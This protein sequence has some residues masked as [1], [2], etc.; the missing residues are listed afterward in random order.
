V[1][2]REDVAQFDLRSV[3]K[4]LHHKPAPADELA[5]VAEPH[6]PLAEAMGL[7][8]DERPLHPAFRGGTIG[9]P[10]VT[11]QV[12]DRLVGVETNVVVGIRR[13]EGAKDEAR[14]FDVGL[15][16]RGAA[17]RE[18]FGRSSRSESRPSSYPSARYALRNSRSQGLCVK[19]QS[20]GTHG[21]WRS[22]KQ[23]SGWGMIARWRPSG[24][25]RAAMPCGL[26]LGLY[27]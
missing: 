21:H 18:R 23:R 16:V 2:T 8:V 6:G 4:L 27:G 26:P 12:H 24:E 14:R 20:G 25:H 15:L 22:W 5:G 7:P 19:V 1:A 13:L 11:D 10:A 9:R 3:L 17:S